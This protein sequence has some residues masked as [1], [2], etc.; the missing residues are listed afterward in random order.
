MIAC[1]ALPTV[2][3]G[4]GSPA[5]Y[6]RLVHEKNA[7]IEWLYQAIEK[8]AFEEAFRQKI[9]FLQEKPC[10]RTLKRNPLKRH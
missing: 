1:V 3:P 6:Q 8:R 9:E 2:G 10:R 5:H 7:E 4:I